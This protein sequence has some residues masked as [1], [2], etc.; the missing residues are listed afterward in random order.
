MKMLPSVLICA[1][2][3]GCATPNESYWTK[4]PEGQ[5]KVIT[6][7]EY[8]GKVFFKNL[9]VIEFDEQGDFW[10]PDQVR[11][12]QD[13]IDY[14]KRPLVVVYIHGWLNNAK[15]TN[16]D[17]FNF[18]KLLKSINETPLGKTM[19]VCGVFI[20]WR[21]EGVRP[22]WKPLALPY[23]G[24]FWSRKSATERVA[25]VPL[26]RTLTLLSEDAHRK[27]GGKAIFI[28]HSF[29]GRVLERTFGQWLAVEGSRDK[30]VK[31][32]ADLV[33][34]INPANESLYAYQIKQALRNKPRGARPVIVSLTSKTDKATNDMWKL[35]ADVRKFSKGSKEFRTYYR[36]ANKTPENQYS[37][38]SQTAGH[39]TRQLTHRLKKVEPK[40][41]YD[42]KTFLWWNISK[43]KRD[44]FLIRAKDGTKQPYMLEPIA[45]DSGGG[46]YQTPIGGY[47]V[48]QVPDEILHDHGGYPD[49]GGIF[50]AQMVDLLGA[51][52]KISEASEDG[53]PPSISLAPV[54]RS[55]PAK[56]P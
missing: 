13:M 32:I 23:Y 35:A 50:N 44:Y 42:R 33:L 21:G 15:P 29:G 26:S 22:E 27:S 40:E 49:E 11:S 10:S 3:A 34:L 25:S 14:A 55:A 1:L 2:L 41:T 54:E 12:A 48:I 56:A 5:G 46:K 52:F 45:T 37:F 39:D 24:T 36:G 19:D 9:R 31:S 47:W 30:N 7:Y 28:G 43:A 16:K 38:V 8:D 51:V 4:S 18:N 17:L 20:G 6:P 53:P